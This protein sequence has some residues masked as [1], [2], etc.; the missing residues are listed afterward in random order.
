ME[1]IKEKHSQI[2][3]RLTELV[4]STKTK[5]RISN[6]EKNQC[7]KNKAP[8]ANTSIIHSV[9]DTSLYFPVKT[10]KI[11]H[12]KNPQMIPWVIEYENGIKIIAKNAGMASSNLFQ[13]IFVMGFI[14]KTP[15]IIKAGAV[16]MAGIM[17][18]KGDKNMKGKNNNPAVI[19]VSPR[20]PPC[21][22]PTADSM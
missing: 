20:R 21:S 15:T 8:T 6:I 22:I 17:D 10:F 3:S 13:L 5:H 14:I 2:L 11:V 7:P 1:I 18:N 4:E 12:D 9:T 16:A 19:A